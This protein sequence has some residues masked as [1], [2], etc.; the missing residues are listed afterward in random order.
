MIDHLDASLDTCDLRWG[1]DETKEA[2][3]EKGM[4]LGHATR[5]TIQDSFLIRTSVHPM[6]TI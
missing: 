5:G 2:A 3:G 6:I 1:E 4:R